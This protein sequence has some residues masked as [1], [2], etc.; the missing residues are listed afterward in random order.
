M[1]NVLR[2]ARVDEAVHFSQFCDVPQVHGCIL[3]DWGHEGL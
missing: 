2:E 3:R 1:D